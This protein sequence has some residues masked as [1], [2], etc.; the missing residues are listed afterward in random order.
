MKEVLDERFSA[1]EAKLDALVAAAPSPSP[2]RR[3]S[4]PFSLK[5]RVGVR[6]GEKGV[7]VLSPSSSPSEPPEPPPPPPVPLQRVISTHHC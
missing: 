7:Q 1:L 4:S 2:S 5:G 6:R 3:L